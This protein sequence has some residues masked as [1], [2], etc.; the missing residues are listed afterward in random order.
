MM[1]LYFFIYIKL[2]N[3]SHNNCYICWMKFMNK[4]NNY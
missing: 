2:L 3:L 1:N 4:C